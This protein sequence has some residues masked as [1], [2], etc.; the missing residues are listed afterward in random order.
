[1]EENALKEIIPRAWAAAE[2]AK[3]SK[4]KVAST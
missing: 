2:K 3:A 1:M 4:H